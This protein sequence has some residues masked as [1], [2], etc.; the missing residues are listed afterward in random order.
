MKVDIYYVIPYYK[1]IYETCNIQYTI[2]SQKCKYS[3]D[4]TKLYWNYMILF[5][6]YTYVLLCTTWIHICTCT[7]TCTYE[8]NNNYKI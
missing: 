4:I 8:L 3:Q 1:N 7:C 6:Y 5:N 2:F